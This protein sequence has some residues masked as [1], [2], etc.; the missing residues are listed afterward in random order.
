M[1]KAS[2][3]ADPRKSH[4]QGCIDD[5]GASSAVSAGDISAIAI[6]MLGVGRALDL[7]IVMRAPRAACD[8][9]WYASLLPGLIES[10]D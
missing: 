5:L 9:E 1:N 4:L 3:H 10:V 6:N 2:C 7:G 8:N